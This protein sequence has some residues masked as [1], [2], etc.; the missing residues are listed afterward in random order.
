MVLHNKKEIFCGKNNVFITK[1]KVN[2]ETYANNILVFFN[3]E[4]II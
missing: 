2:T 3:F 4:L 1:L